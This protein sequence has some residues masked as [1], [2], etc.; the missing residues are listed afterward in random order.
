MKPFSHVWYIY[1]PVNTFMDSFPHLRVYQKGENGFTF[2]QLV[3]RARNIFLKL[4]TCTLHVALRGR[5]PGEEMLGPL[6][7]QAASGL[8]LAFPFLG[9]FPGPQDYPRRNTPSCVFK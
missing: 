5:V 1:G 6:C 2:L 9:A 4:T 7:V 3:R 8:G